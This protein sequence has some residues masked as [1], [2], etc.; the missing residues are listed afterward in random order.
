MT[1]KTS[2]QL[3]FLILCTRYHHT[4]TEKE[5]II[6]YFDENIL[7]IDTFIQFA[8]QHGV[9]PI[10][11]HSLKKIEHIP[12][13]ILK[14]LKVHYHIFVQKN[15]LMSAEVI[16]LIKLFQENDIKALAIKGPVLAQILHNDITLRQYGDLDILVHP[17]HVYQAAMLL[18]THHYKLYGSIDLL[19]NPTWI[20]LAKDMTLINQKNNIV[21]EL[22]WKLFHNTFAKADSNLDLWKNIDQVLLHKKNIPTL[23]KD[24]LL[25][26]LCIHGSK[27]LWE[28]LGWLTDI[29]RLIRQKEISWENVLHTAYHFQSEKMFFLALSL[30]QKLYNTPLPP[31]IQIYLKGSSIQ[32][33]T[34]K[35]HMLIE[36]PLPK[37]PSFKDVFYRKHLHASMQNSFLHYLKFW[38]NVLFSYNDAAILEKG[39]PFEKKSIFNPIRPYN[40]IKKFILKKL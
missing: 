16:K 30:T 35:I 3:D 12:S 38:K 36:T 23:Q 10:L 33:L 34:K 25:T 18:G 40:L 24:I 9:V 32:K 5:R 31:E 28:R 37:P 6:T 15:I 20:K 29:D 11:Y 26:Y 22:H 39:E 8:R 19:Q 1:N 2:T 4:K 17:D 14:K 21:L 13:H 27:H 7:E